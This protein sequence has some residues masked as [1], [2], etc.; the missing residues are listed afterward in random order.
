MSLQ[1][2]KALGLLVGMIVGAGMFALPYTIMK[3][4][5]AWSFFHVVLVLILVTITHA[6]YAAVILKDRRHARLPGYAREYLGEAGFWITL[7][8][9]LL[10]YWGFLLA[11]G[12]L[13]GGF[14]AHIIPLSESVLAI[15]FFVIISPLLLFRLS[16]IGTVNFV[17]TL[18]EVFLPILLFI[19]WWQRFDFAAVSLGGDG[20][21][22]LPYGVFLFAFSG[23]SVIPE[24]I[25][26]LGSSARKKIFPVIVAGSIIVLLVYAAFSAMI[27]GLAGGL[28]SEDAL[29]V[30][31]T[32]IGEGAF[33]IG[34]IL[35]LCAVATSY[36]ALGLELRYT[37]E[38]DLSRSRKIA[39][40]FTAFVPL[41]AYLLGM[42]SF[43]FL[44]NVIG[45]VGVGIEGIIIASLAYRVLGTRIAIAGGLAVALLL[46]A[47]FELVRTG[48][49]V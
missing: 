14:F 26:T 37:F 33:I 32:S 31:A 18:P 6:L 28:P 7:I 30:L 43:I 34:T 35:A 39:W 25:D 21:W 10:A 1:T 4:G 12:I 5:I 24:I 38:Y 16:R 46:G 42:R 45:G 36:I 47:L 29:S 8:S 27:I 44:I 20:S 11:Y 19:F 13:I 41:I 15:A 23:A 2:L 48:G 17:L 49:F 9:R 22:F 3:A 40:V